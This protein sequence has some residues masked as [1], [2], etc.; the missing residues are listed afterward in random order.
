M[1][2][3][4]NKIESN[5]PRSDYRNRDFSG[6]WTKHF[7]NDF[8]DSIFNSGIVET[9]E[10]YADYKNEHLPKSLFKFFPPSQ[11]S[12]INLENDS[13]FLSSPRNFNDPFDSFVCIEAEKFKKIYLLK[14]LK[15][16]NLISKV[17]NEDK[18]SEKEYYQ[19]YH[20]WTKESEPPFMLNKRRPKHFI[21]ALFDIRN[22]KSGSLSSLLYEIV[23]EARRECRKKIDYIRNMEFK[24]S[25]FSNFEDETELLN[26]TTMW[27]HYAD[28]HQG[29]SIKYK[30]DF[31]NIVNGKAIKC[32]L[33]PI[34]YTA[35]VPQISPRELMRSK[36]SGEE[37]KLNKP[38]LK[39][40]YKT[41]TTKSR[42]WSYEKEWRL[43][44]SNYDSDILTN[45]TIPFLK[46]EA[47]FL[48][49]RI[50]SNLKKFLVQIAEK[51]EIPIYQTKLSNET[52]Q[53]RLENLYLRNIQ[54]EEY[55]NRSQIIY[56]LENHN[57]KQEKINLLNKERYN[58]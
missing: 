29:F 32:G 58:L 20:S 38:V 52:F 26:N 24:I 6:Y 16:L 21:F 56:Q 45:N 54:E 5:F 43:I 53:L 46:A 28:N 48:G 30:T 57:D 7:V 8:V 36:F 19:L 25:C 49:A 31:D 9:Q 37:L 55:R 33:F 4:D 10:K 51:K 22:K 42:S 35:K 11:Y 2:D 41:M 40:A 1:I 15:E 27:S 39:T 44:L 17:E 23:E 12:L 50:E 14:R 13:L 3:W 47:I 34:H 18:I